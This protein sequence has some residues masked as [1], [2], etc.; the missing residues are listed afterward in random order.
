MSLKTSPRRRTLSQVE[1]DAYKVKVT[2]SNASPFRRPKRRAE[3]GCQRRRRKAI[4]RRFWVHDMTHGAGFVPDC[5]QCDIGKAALGQELLHT[6][7]KGQPMD[8]TQHAVLER[9]LR[10]LRDHKRMEQS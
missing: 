1:R 2:L 7:A 8:P 10:K 9:E 5:A 3:S 4:D 6:Y